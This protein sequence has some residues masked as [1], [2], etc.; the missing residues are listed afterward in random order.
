MGVITYL[1]T[2]LGQQVRRTFS[3]RDYWWQKLLRLI[4]LEIT[5]K[6]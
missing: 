5:A 6:E 3:P 1:H 2:Y 4:Y